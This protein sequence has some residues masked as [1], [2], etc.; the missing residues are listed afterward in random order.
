MPLVVDHIV[1]KSR[2]GDDTLGNLAAA[3]YRCNE[4]KGARTVGCDP[5]SQE[6]VVLFHPRMQIWDEHFIWTEAGLLI[7]GVTPTGG[8]TVEALRLNNAY[9]T[10]SRKI[11]IAEDWHPPLLQ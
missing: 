7:V 8:A 11:W 10:E 5:I 6:E 9:I 4:F 2:G 1:P 3:C